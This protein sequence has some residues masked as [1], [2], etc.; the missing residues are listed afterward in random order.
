MDERNLNDK[1][2]NSENESKAKIFFKTVG[3]IAL[4]L[5]L[6]AITVL[7]VNLGK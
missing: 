3:I 4:S 1:N 6:A 2:V 5:F 7:V